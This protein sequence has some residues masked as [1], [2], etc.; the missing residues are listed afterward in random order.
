MLGISRVKLYLLEV[1]V[2]KNSTYTLLILGPDSKVRKDL[3][4]ELA[5]L[6]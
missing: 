3:M 5:R 4:A 1:C 6:Q 2:K